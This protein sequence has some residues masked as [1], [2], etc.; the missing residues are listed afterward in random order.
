M[1]TS[2]L[3]ERD[4]AIH[5]LLHR[6]QAGSRGIVLVSGEAGI[7]KTSLLRAAA[8][9]TGAPLCWGACDALQTPHPL[10]PWLELE[11]VSP[12]TAAGRAGSRPGC[13]PA[14]RRSGRPA[15]STDRTD[16]ACALAAGAGNA[17]SGHCARASTREQPFDLTLREL[18]VLDLLCHG[19]RNAEIAGKLSRS[20]R[21]VDHHLAAIF[22]KLGV[23]NRAAAVRVAAG[24]GLQDG[25]S[26][27]AN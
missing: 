9:Q 2:D 3:V 16:A 19:L 13:R 23:D 5:T 7:G 15:G 17:R 20:V 26:R 4:A 11:A 24:L 1:S 21:T 12:R 18:E 27:S 14:A 22:A 6:W 8:R 10:G 25:Q